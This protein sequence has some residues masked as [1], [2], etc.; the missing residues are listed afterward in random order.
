MDKLVIM[1]GK[2]LCGEVTVSGAKNAAVAVIPATLLV[3]GPCRIEN[4][5]N[6]KD[7]HVILDILKYL[8]AKIKHINEYTIEINCTDIKSCNP[9][10]ELTSKM[11]ASYYLIGA[12][13]GRFNRANVPP[14]GGCNFGSRPIDMHI[15]GFEA[16]GANISIDKGIIEAE[17]EKLVAAPVFLDVVS[18][19]ATIN[20]MLAAVRAQG[21]TV[22]ENAAKEPHV[23]DVANFLNAMGANIRG[24]GTDVIKIK[25]VEKLAGGTYSII[26]DQIEAGTFMIAAAAT[27]GDVLVKNVIPKHLESLTAK[28]TEMSV[29]VEEYDDSIRVFCNKPIM[30]ANV[31]TMP[32]PGFPTDLQ[33]QI[34]TLLSVAEGTSIVTE[35]IWDNRFQYVDELKRFGAQISVDGKV[36]V[37]EG[38]KRLSGAPVKATDLRAGAS[39]IIAGL[40]AEGITEIY[41][42]C[43]IDRGYENM[44]EKLRKLGAQIV[45]KSD[46]GTPQKIGE[47]V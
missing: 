47:V 16:L 3:E 42:L 36:A 34:V 12:L 17:A 13:L 44:E 28:L 26:P 45:R 46:D 30:K 33:P 18:V 9:P 19:G 43:H 22:I 27:K 23:V 24:A 1:G 20:I 2:R 11:R 4:V 37:I 8:G 41:E 25:G 29:N 40:M 35:S 5:P 38:V 39:M 15:K 7:V 21:T 31:K 32:Y 14:P 6:I 10:Y